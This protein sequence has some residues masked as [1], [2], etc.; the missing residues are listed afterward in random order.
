MNCV[1]R[2]RT[3]LGFVELTVHDGV[4]SIVSVLESRMDEMSRKRG[5]KQ[6]LKM[7]NS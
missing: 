5:G 3:D 6:R 7:P 1:E 2:F 4:R